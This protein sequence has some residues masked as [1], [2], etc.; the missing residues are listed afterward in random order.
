MIDINNTVASVIY[1]PEN[2][3]LDKRLKDEL[4]KTIDTFNKEN[5]EDEYCAATLRSYKIEQE[6]AKKQQ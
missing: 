3:E 2:I 1:S 6:M 4:E 5:L